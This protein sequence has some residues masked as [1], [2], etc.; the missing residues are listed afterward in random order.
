MNEVERNLQDAM[1]VTK[2]L[3]LEPFIVPGKKICLLSHPILS[4]VMVFFFGSYFL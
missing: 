1:A 3:F 4:P 2:N